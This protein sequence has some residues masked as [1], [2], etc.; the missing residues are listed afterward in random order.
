VNADR[1]RIELD[2][3]DISTL[4][5]YQRAR[6]GIGYFPQAATIFRGV[7]V[8]DDIR[9]ALQVVER[10][11]ARREVRLDALLD[12]F[13]IARALR[14]RA[15]SPTASAAASTSFAR[16]RR[17]RAICCSTSRW[18]ASTPGRSVTSRRWCAS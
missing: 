16:S 18:P 17:G 13:D 9:R 2:G 12:E 14:R 15:S 10:D 4:S 3:R 6:L 8:E 5:M 7:N 1:G 11:R